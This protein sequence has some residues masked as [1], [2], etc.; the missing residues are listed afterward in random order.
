[1]QLK[2][3]VAVVTGAGSGIGKAAALLLAREGA[4]IAALDLSENELEQTEGEISEQRREAVPCVADVS[5][6]LQM[7]RAI[8]RA[9]EQWGRVG[10]RL[11]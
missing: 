9:A 7:R 8:N 4:R 3:K 5:D 11:R 10:H 1:M 6:P 2:G